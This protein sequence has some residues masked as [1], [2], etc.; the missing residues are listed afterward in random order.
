VTCYPILSAEAHLTVDLPGREQTGFLC[1]VLD[2]AETPPLTAYVIHL[3][4]RH[5]D[6]RPGKAKSMLGLIA[7]FGDRP[8]VILGDFNALAPSDYGARPDKLATLEKSGREVVLG[9]RVVS[10]LPLVWL[11]GRLRHRRTRSG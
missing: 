3:D 7:H 9:E 5:E 8:H 10:Y 11:R 6:A 1:A 4:H 2:M